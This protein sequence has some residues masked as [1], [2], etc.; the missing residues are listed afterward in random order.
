MT[1]DK[2]PHL[3]RGLASLLGP[4]SSVPANSN[5]SSLEKELNLPQKPAEPVDSAKNSLD[6]E[7]IKPNPFQPRKH[8]SDDELLDL[9]R[10]I[11]ANGIIQ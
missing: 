2:R 10:S 6:I 9:S 4:I 1:K 11:E 5:D 8:W 7:K 3:G